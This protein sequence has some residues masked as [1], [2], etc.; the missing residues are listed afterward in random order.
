MDQPQQNIGPWLL[1]LIDAQTGDLV[2]PQTSCRLVA[3][4][5]GGQ[6]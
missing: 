2:W 3:A 1:S 5:D 6:M 4:D